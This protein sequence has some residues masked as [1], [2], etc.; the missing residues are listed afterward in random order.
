MTIVDASVATAWYVRIAT[1]DAALPVRNRPFLA[2]PE[3]LK[4]ELT[5]SLLK[6]VRVGLL[7]PS[8]IRHAQSQIRTLVEIW[9]P[10]ERL[11]TVATETA[12]SNNHKIYDC[13]YLALALERREPLATADR[14]LA[15]LA[16]KLSIETHLIEPAL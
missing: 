10:D 9:V 1:S 6:Y 8:A 11:L 4:V 16:A 14:R 7:E 2:A 13:L 5:S 3:F 12:R 15:A